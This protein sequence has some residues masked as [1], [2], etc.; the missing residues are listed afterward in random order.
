MKEGPITI[1]DFHL[2]GVAFTYALAL[3]V[4]QVGFDGRRT[5]AQNGCPFGRFDV[6]SGG[7]VR[8]PM[9]WGTDSYAP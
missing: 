2:I 9:K 8:I 5:L 1:R 4:H 6:H 3:Q 7:Y